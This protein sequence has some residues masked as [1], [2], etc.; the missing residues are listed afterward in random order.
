MTLW[1]I[2]CICIILIISVGT[3]VLC[4][5]KSMYTSPLIPRVILQV[6]RDKNDIHP[7]IAEVMNHLKDQNPRWEYSLMDDEDIAKYLRTHHP[8][9]VENAWHSIN[10]EYGAV[11]SDLFRY[12][13][14][15]DNGGVYF[16]DKSS[17]NRP[18]DDII[19]F[20][21][22]YILSHWSS[23]EWAEEIGN[24]HGEFQQWHII[25]IPRHP[26]LR[27]V[28]S[29]VLDNIENYDHSRDGVGIAVLHLTG[30]V[31]YTNAILPI[32][33][34]YPH[35]IAITNDEL[36]LIYNVLGTNHFNL[37]KDAYYKL[38]ETPIILNLK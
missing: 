9:R 1:I 30:P 21:D 25:C 13:W 16:D 4:R 17:I 23:K 27:E 31:A 3:M 20:D 18:L 5:S 8:G 29:K 11:R 19:R 14:M 37:R 35:R 26:F 7:K 24:E 10:P 22:E 6:V 38:L 12:L 15:Y 36:G 34:A 33:T 2:I 32:L 28:I